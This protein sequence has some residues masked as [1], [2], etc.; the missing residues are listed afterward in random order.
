MF[1]VHVN[2]LKSK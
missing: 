1:N 2:R